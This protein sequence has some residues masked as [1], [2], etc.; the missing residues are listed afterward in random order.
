MSNIP[1]TLSKYNYLDKCPTYRLLC[2]SM[3]I[4]INVGHTGYFV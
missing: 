4:K 1:G 3:T 2:L